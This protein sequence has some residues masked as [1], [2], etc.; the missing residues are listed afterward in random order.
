MGKQMKELCGLREDGETMAF[1]R[2]PRFL[3]MN[4]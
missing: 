1:E 2:E 3:L 4:L